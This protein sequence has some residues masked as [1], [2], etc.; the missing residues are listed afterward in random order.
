MNYELI[1]RAVLHV[2][3]LLLVS[4]KPL[5]ATNKSM[6][7]HI[8]YIYLPIWYVYTLNLCNICTYGYQKV[9]GKSPIAQCELPNSEC[10]VLLHA[11]S[12]SELTT[13][14]ADSGSRTEGSKKS[15]ENKYNKSEFTSFFLQNSASSNSFRSRL[16]PA[17]H[18]QNSSNCSRYKYDQS[19]SRIF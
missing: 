19:I 3:P 10:K 18:F 11:A 16:W 15:A 8:F 9:M 12:T 2:L 1:L 5:P 14:R 4:C 17:L 7:C 6:E 13:S